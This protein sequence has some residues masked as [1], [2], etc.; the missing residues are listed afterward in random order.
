MQLTAT[1]RAALP[2]T[3]LL[4]LHM[5]SQLPKLQLN[6]YQILAGAHLPVLSASQVAL[7]L[8]SFC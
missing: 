2:H 4:P 3:A 7:L 5:L 6:E 1:Q 8:G